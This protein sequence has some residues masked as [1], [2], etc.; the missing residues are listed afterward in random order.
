MSV[1]VE[2]ENLPWFHPNLNRHHAE[3][4]LLQNGQDGSYLLRTSATNVGEYSLSVRCSSS[5]KHFQIGW[6]G[7]HYVFGMGKFSSL[8][9]FVAHFEKKPLIGGESGLL[10]LL[11]FPYPRDVAEP[12]QYDTIHVHAEWGERPTSQDMSHA[13][14]ESLNS[15]E[16]YLTKQ[17]GMVKNW[18]A[19]WFVL[20][21]SE[22]KYYKTKMDEQPIRTLDLDKCFGVEEDFECGKENTFRIEMPGRTFR[23]YANSEKDK[24]SWLQILKWKM[25][26]KQMGV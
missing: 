12:V 18:K 6:D 16:G 14:P 26:K 3:A 22:L 9:D 11:K 25:E 24:N 17:G 20:C 13:Q 19:R 8:M 15:K 7:T 4:I 23:I 10:T 5:V 2:V 1:C 21:K